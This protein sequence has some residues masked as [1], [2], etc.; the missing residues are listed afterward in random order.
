MMG[1]LADLLAGPSVRALGETDCEDIDPGLIAQPTNTLSSTSYVVVGLLILV[2][3]RRARL[4]PMISA[5][6]PWLAAVY[7]TAVAL[8]GV[9][10][11]LFHGPQPPGSQWL[12]DWAI[13]AIVGMIALTDLYVLTLRPWLSTGAVLAVLAGSGL[14]MAFSPG[15]GYAVAAVL[16]VTAAVGEVLVVYQGLRIRGRSGIDGPW[17]LLVPAS[18]LV[19]AGASYALGRTGSPA[20]DPDSL[21]QLHGLWHVCTALTFAWWA[22]VALFGRTGTV[23]RSAADVLRG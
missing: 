13:V 10:S 6:A 16:F 1:V 17:G 2:F 22:R 18:L 7:G 19:L 23:A 11:V 3:A 5:A 20:C 12:H 14:A 21:I 15:I 9:G 4:D 8:E